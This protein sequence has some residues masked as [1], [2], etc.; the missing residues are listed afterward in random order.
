MRVLPG[1]TLITHLVMLDLESTPPIEL[2]KDYPYRGKKNKTGRDLRKPGT[3]YVCP[4]CK[5]QYIAIFRGQK[6]C[7]AKCFDDTAKNAY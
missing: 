3:T 4:N 7:S 2:D 5:N 6:Y 1:V